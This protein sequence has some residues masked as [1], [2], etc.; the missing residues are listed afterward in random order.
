M[1]A[2]REPD[3]NGQVQDRLKRQKCIILNDEGLCRAQQACESKI[4]VG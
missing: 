2:I 1:N 4:K 3:K